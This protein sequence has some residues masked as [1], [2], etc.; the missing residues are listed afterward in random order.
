MVVKTKVALAVAIPSKVTDDGEIE[1][2]D[3]AG[4][5]LPQLRV[6]VDLNPAR[7]VMKRIAAA[8]LPAGI[9]SRLSE[10]VNSKEGTAMDT[11]LLWLEA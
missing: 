5:P 2:V 4:I 1:Q 6:T 10:A 9:A 8:L 3:P 7:G 11:G